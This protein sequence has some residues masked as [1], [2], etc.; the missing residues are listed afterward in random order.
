MKLVVGMDNLED[1]FNWQQNE[2]FDYYGQRAIPC[3]TRYKPKEAE[4]ILRE[5]GS[6]YR[7]LKNRIQC[8]YKILGFEM[9]ETSAGKK[10]MIVQDAQMIQ[11]ISTPRRSFQG[12]RYLKVS[13]IPADIGPYDPAYV[14]EVPKDMEQ[15]LREA[16]LL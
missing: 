13:D 8:R 16:G 10:C 12:W 3:W 6:I 11:T 7:V 5:G 2:I 4:N 1:F 15:D 9:V 14:Q